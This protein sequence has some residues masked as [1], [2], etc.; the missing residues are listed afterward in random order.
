M[1]QISVTEY[2]CNSMEYSVLSVLICTYGLGTLYKSLEESTKVQILFSFL[3]FALLRVQVLGEIDLE[4]EIVA[5]DH[6]TN[7]LY[8]VPLS[9]I[10]VE[11]E[12]PYTL[13][14]HSVRRVP[15]VT[16]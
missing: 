15:C 3:E 12:R 6:E 5:R 13:L 8:G 1:D 16:T 9:G 14:P 10:Y 11:Y 2:L 4:C 7:T